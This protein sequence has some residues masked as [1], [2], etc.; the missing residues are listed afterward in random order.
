MRICV[1]PGDILAA[2]ADEKA[3]FELVIHHLGIARPQNILVVADHREAVGLV[4]DR[5]AV[6]DL[7]NP[8]HARR[9][10]FQRACTEGA[11]GHRIT[12]PPST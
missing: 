5:L 11:S 10:W 1:L 9:A 12:S 6:P 3:E 4:I 8:E 7:R 2:L